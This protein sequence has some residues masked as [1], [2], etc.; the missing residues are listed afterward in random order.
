MDTALFVDIN[1]EYE[2]PYAFDVDTLLTKALKAAA[3]TEEIEGAEVSVTLVDN[4]R[5]HELNQQYR[6]IDSPT[7]VL[8]FA[9]TEVGEDELEIVLDEEADIEEPQHLGDIVISVQ[10]AQ[11][12]AEEYGH[13]FDRE[14]AFLAVHGFLHLIGY[15]HMDDASEKEMFSKQEGILESIGLTRK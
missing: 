7:D 13:G 2:T 12:Q 11:E 9:M 5:I 10:R 6:G 3:V 4:A 15:D 1:H 8:S 14:L